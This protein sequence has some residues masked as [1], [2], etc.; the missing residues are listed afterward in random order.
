MATNPI[1]RTRRDGTK[2]YKV[3]WREAGDPKQHSRT[4]LSLPDAR[5]FKRLVEIG[6]KGNDMYPGDAEMVR[7][8]LMTPGESADAAVRA[9][10]PK[11]T[12]TIDEAMTRFLKY[13]ESQAQN[14]PTDRTMKEY[15]SIQRNYIT[16][17]SIADLDV[18][19]VRSKPIQAWVNEQKTRERRDRRAATRISNN[20]MNKVLALLSSMFKWTMMG[21]SDPHPSGDTPLRALS[22]PMTEVEYFRVSPDRRKEKQV[23]RKE[24][25]ALFFLC[26]Y[27]VDPYWADMVV[28]SALTGMR[29]GE[30]SAI[31]VE[32]CNLKTG[33]I[34][35]DRR[36]SQGIAEAGTKGS[37]EGGDY[38]IS[39][40]ARIPAEINGLLTERCQGKKKTALVFDGPHFSTKKKWI[41]SLD[42][43]RWKELEKVLEA[44]DLDRG[45]RHHHLRH[46]LTTYLSD[47][48]INLKTIKG[49]VG[50]ADSSVTD[51]YI[52]LTEESWTLVMSAIAPLTTSLMAV[53]TSAYEA[54]FE[55]LKNVNVVA[56]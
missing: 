2:T 36:F 5:L 19:T 31:T 45:F 29:F 55:R 14:R 9:M 49:V 38:L 54:F 21:K 15:R 4:F 51:R 16:G 26:A 37:S 50:H 24:D 42:N 34:D 52:H 8:G 40:E 30:V 56:A 44:V 11:G 46:S 27:Q 35:L 23:L 6:G 7:R 20:S 22:S 47:S 28:V 53:R 48:G 25:Y 18:A 1:P 13:R 43:G 12:V 41:A 10:V 33:V 17:T 32:Q 3:Q 39:R